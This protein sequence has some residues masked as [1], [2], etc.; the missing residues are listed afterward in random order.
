MI[1]SE[2][3]RSDPRSEVGLLDIEAFPLVRDLAKTGRR[4]DTNQAGAKH[5]TRTDKTW[6]SSLRP[7]GKVGCAERLAAHTLELIAVAT[8]G[9]ED[10]FKRH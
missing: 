10:S 4:G 2:S 8:Y 6:E 3:A 7:V 1:R 5:P 9:N